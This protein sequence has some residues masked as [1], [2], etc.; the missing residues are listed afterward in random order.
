MLALASS[1]ASSCAA[2]TALTMLQSA[3][4]LLLLLLAEDEDDGCHCHTD[5]RPLSD[6]AAMWYVREPEVEG[7]Q[8]TETECAACD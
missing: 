5:T 6:T 3:W 4:L 8:T 7:A 1:A 2:S